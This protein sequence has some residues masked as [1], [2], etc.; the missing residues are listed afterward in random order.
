MPTAVRGPGDGDPVTSRG[1]ATKR[2]RSTRTVKFDISDLIEWETLLRSQQARIGRAAREIEFQNAR[3]LSTEAKRL[4]P[5]STGARSPASSKYGPLHQKIQ[6]RKERDNSKV[7]IGGAFYG[8]FQEFGTSKMRP[9]PFLGPAIKRQ[10][11]PFAE[12][13]RRAVMKILSRSSR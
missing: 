2:G 6:A 13:A 11:R 5:R 12:D 10:R 9:N 7:G 3:E 4:A 1:I 8:A